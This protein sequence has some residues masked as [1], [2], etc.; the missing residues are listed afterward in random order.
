MA[1]RLGR[2]NAKEHL[3]GSNLSCWEKQMLAVLDF[4]VR[5]HGEA[6]DL[7]TTMAQG[8][9]SNQVFN[10]SIVAR[11]SQR[12]RSASVTLDHRKDTPY[13][14]THSHL[15][16]WL[17]QYRLPRVFSADR[18]RLATSFGT[19]GCRRVSAAKLVCFSL[20]MTLRTSRQL[21]VVG[22]YL[23]WRL[24]R[25]TRHLVECGQIGWQFTAIHGTVCDSIR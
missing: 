23:S 22:Q 3:P 18:D 25:L 2:K 20:C 10:A 1:G 8:Q 5:E 17:H 6:T 14:T 13:S 4:R 21:A 16:N 9:H 7:R 15:I 24:S 19:L 12:F 11:K